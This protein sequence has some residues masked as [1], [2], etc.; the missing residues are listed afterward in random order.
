MHKTDAP[1]KATAVALS[2]MVVEMGQNGLTMTVTSH[3]LDDQ[4]ISHGSQTYVGP[5]ASET[6]GKLDELVLAVEEELAKIH[7][8]VE[9]DGPAVTDA[10]PNERPK[11]LLAAR[12][13]SSEDQTPQI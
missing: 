5:W 3:L 11:G 7:F 4:G 12:L 13:E 1:C 10:E 6:I 9:G 8:K 2:R